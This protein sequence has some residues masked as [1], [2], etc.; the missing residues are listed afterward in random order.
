[1]SYTLTDDQK[2]WAGLLATLVTTDNN[3]KTTV[4]DN[5]LDALE[6]KFSNTAYASQVTDFKGWVKGGV[7]PANPH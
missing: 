1:M 3:A 5:E 4:T 7:R 2:G 6:S